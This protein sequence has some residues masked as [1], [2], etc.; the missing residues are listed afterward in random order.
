[1]SAR[2]L[3][4]ATAVA[5]S[6]CG[7]LPGRH[8]ALDDAQGRYD[9]ARADPHI[10]AL[11]DA[12]LQ[13]AGRALQAARQ[14][15]AEGRSAAEVEHLAYLANQRITIARD[16]AGSRAS[17]ATVAALAA[18][19]ERLLQALRNREANAAGRAPESPAPGH[20]TLLK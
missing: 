8:A 17:Q 4:L 11:A 15:M 13:R 10:V 9:L 12:E 5:L 3:V 1:M 19:R 6:D 2:G 14:A 18:D 20:S 16:E 7:S